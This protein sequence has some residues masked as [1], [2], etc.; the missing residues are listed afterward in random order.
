MIKT[1]LAPLVGMK[2]DVGVLKTAQAVAQLSGAHI[3]ALHVRPDAAQ[4][5]IRTAGFDGG[6]GASC[7]ITPEIVQA[8]EQDFKTT[9]AV[10]HRTFDDFAAAADI[11]KTRNQTESKT[12]T[13]RFLQMVGDQIQGVVAEARVR[14]LVVLGRPDEISGLGMQGVGD[15]LIRAGRPV[16]LATDTA[17]NSIGHNIAIA[18]KDS[19]EAARAM[20]AAMPLLEKAQRVVILTAAENGDDGKLAAISTKRLADQLAWHG[21]PAEVRSIAPGADASESILEAAHRFGADLLVMGGYG[22]SRAR[23]FVFGGFTRR[24]LQDSP[25]P[26]LMSH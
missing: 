24:V 10:A 12:V 26:V 4:V 23:E 19:A 7:L 21:I 20:T 25:L 16:L 11:P 15:V 18:W 22:H 9:A 1:I 2:S 13:A 3:D 17:P 14:E 8:L 6:T 5:A